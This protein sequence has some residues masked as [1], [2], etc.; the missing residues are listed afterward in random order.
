MRPGA[1]ALAETVRASEAHRFGRAVAVASGIFLLLIISG[2]GQERHPV[3][4]GEPAPEIQAVD[5]NE[6]PLRLADYRG[7]VVLVQFWAEACCADVVSALEGLF[8]KHRDAGFVV[9]GINPV[10]PKERVERVVKAMGIDFVVGLDQLKLTQRRYDVHGIPCSFLVDRDGVIREK[11][12]G[13][14]P[15]QKLERKLEPL[16]R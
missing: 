9:I 8:N 1:Y 2:C 3:R 15:K 11:I 14:I 12:L 13:D 7:K 16:L 10:E 4:K 5:L 6:R